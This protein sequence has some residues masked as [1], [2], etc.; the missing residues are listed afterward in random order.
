MFSPSGGKQLK[1]CLREEDSNLYIF[2]D[3]SQGVFGSG[4]SDNNFVPEE[5][6]IK[7]PYFPLVNN[8]RTTSEINSFAQSF[9]TGKNILTGHSNRVG[10]LPEIITYKDEKDLKKS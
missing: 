10:Y 4:S 2:F 8:Y 5:V 7:G 3:R 6:P 9:R 1:Q